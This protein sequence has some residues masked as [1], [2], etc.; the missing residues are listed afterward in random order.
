MENKYPKFISSYALGDDLYEGKSQEK[1]AHAICNH[2]TSIDAQFLDDSKPIIPRLIGLEG[3]WGSGKSNVV[4]QM[5]AILKEKYFFFTYDAWG[6]Q[7]DL[8]RRSLLE[9]L[10]DE[11]IEKEML[12]GKTFDREV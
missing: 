12:K 6:H 8:Q 10:T 9:R 11:L 7:E 3:T 1:L 2:I 4:A 5:Q